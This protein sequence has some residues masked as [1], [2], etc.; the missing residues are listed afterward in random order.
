MSYSDVMQKMMHIKLNQNVSSQNE[1]NKILYKTPNLLLIKLSIDKTQFLDSRNKKYIYD[2][3]DGI[4][5]LDTNENIKLK[6][7]VKINNKIDHNIKKNH[8]LM[9]YR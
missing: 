7:K 8:L 4:F 9:N 2:E 1:I 3:K 6:Y 5:I